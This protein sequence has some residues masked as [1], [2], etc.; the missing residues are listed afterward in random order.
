MRLLDTITHKL[1]SFHGDPPPYAILSHRWRENEVTFQDLQTSDPSSLEGYDK[2]TKTCSI[3]AA[4]G[5]EYA[6]IDSCCIDKTNST[7]LSEAINSM[8]R[9]YQEATIC[10]AYLADV[11]NTV[12][13]ASSF[14]EGEALEDLTEEYLWRS[15]WFARG[16]TL[17]ELIAPS[18]VIFLDRDWDEVGTKLSL[19]RSVSRITGI[20]ESILE[21]TDVESASVAQRMSWAAGR[22]TT[23]VEDE[24]YCLMGLFGVHMPLLYGEGVN[25]FFPPTRRDI[26]G[27][28]RLQLV[29]WQGVGRHRAAERH[30]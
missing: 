23:N 12:R 19:R 6:W 13:I 20:P 4:A 26:E 22:T 7:E 3:S 24:A 2:I 11:S 27:L 5:L 17:Q 18:V 25:A 30:A 8:Y 10:Y 14:L 16:W 9:W 29:P 15:E 28:D 21:G 1:K